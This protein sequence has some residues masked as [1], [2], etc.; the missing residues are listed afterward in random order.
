MCVHL[1]LDR[2]KDRLGY[3]VGTLK[4]VCDDYDSCD[5]VDTVVGPFN[6]DL[7]I[8]QLN[9]RGIG[10]KVS[11]LKYLI[12][13]SF[14]NCEPDVMLISETWLTEQSPPISIP[15]YIFVQKPRK[16]KKGGGVS[17]LI[18]Q[19][20]KYQIIDKITF[21]SK[22]FESMIAVINLQNGDNI[23][24]GS[25]Y[26]PPNTNASLYNVEYG[27]LLCSLKKLR[28]TSIILGMDHN[29]DLLHSD[30]HQRTED[31]LKINLDHLLIPTI[32]RP[33]RITKNTATL[34]DN[35]IVSQNCCST[36]ESSVL[37][38]DISDHLPSVCV[39][40][41]AKLSRKKSITIK[42]RDTRK[43]NLEALK[44]SLEGLDWS[45]LSLCTNVNAK[46]EVLHSKLVE[47]ID[48]FVPLRSHTIKYKKLRR[49]LWVSA[50]I[51]Q[52]IN[53]S[54]RL[55][56][57]SIK[58]GVTDVVIREYKEYNKLLQKIKRIAKKNYDGEKCVEYKNN[59]KKLWRIINEISG[60]A[61]NKDCLIDSL[62]VDNIYVY[63]AQKI[64]NMF[65]EVFCN[66]G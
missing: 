11:K 14:E 61:N 19:N 10:S 28:A 2:G 23:A 55:Y 66:S 41:N 33:T 64:A 51:L 63:E 30:K 8:A 44:H 3:H 29:M 26:R 40:K 60:K 57:K 42:S 32:T 24:V 5:Y 50:G 4:G 62:K 54:K 12:D 58:S 34:I 6:E 17:L 36:Y 22:E 35:I 20:I 25:I 27:K 47:K 65:G 45:E 13:H 9:I 1:N 18:K 7:I 46:A 56:A 16:G 52:S 38:D 39:V 15:G 59:T 53:Y 43:C 49:E 48:H 21:E 37:I 31:F